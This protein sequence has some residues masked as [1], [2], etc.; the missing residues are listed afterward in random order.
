MGVDLVIYSG[1][2]VIEGL[3]SGLVIGKM[4]YVEWVKCQLMGIG[5][6]MKVG[7]EGIF[8]L[9]CVIE[10]YLMVSKES[11]QQMVDKMMLF[12]EQF[13]IFNGVIV[14]V[15]WDSVGCDIVCVEIKFDE[16]M[17][18]VK[19][20]DL[21]N[22]LKQ[23]EYVIYFCGYKVNEGIIEVDVCS[24]NVEQLVVVVCCIV[25]VLNKEK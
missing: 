10:Y 1:V 11:G 9:I 6:V 15:V 4:Q 5:W 16:V 13:N 8:G 19:I 25:E 2:K 17:I 14:W 3:I 24:V 22:V 7:K 12:I 20:G 21:V 18:G 23:G